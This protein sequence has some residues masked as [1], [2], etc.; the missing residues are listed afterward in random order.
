MFKEIFSFEI[1]RERR[2]YS[3]STYFFKKKSRIVY[4]ISSAFSMR[5]IFFVFVESNIQKIIFNCYIINVLLLLVMMFSVFLVRWYR[6]LKFTFSLLTTEFIRIP[7]HIN[8]CF[9]KLCPKCQKYHNNFKVI[10][11]V[12]V[13]MSSIIFIFWFREDFFFHLLCCYV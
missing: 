11:I 7:N 3:T 5:I 1:N 4:H 9:F 6:I 10:Q 2:H 13:V 8:A 12:A